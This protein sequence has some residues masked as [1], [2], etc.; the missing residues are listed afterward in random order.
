MVPAARQPYNISPAANGNSIAMNRIARMREAV[1][2][3]CGAAEGGGG[4]SRSF[5]NRSAAITTDGVGSPMPGE[6]LLMLR[7][8]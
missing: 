7:V 1:T 6:A 8:I 3:K 5:R 4:A 2:P